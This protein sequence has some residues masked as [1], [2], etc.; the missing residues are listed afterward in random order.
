MSGNEERA[1]VSRRQRSAEA[2]DRELIERR[3]RRRD[4]ATPVG[5]E[6]I[7]L[8]RVAARVKSL[9]GGPASGVETTAGSDWERAAVRALQ[10]RVQDLEPG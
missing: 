4:P 1:S 8:Q 5:W 3:R 7:V 2:A 6:T 9:G 10:R